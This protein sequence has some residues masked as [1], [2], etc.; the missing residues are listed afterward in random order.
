[1]EGGIETMR[2]KDNQKLT[3]CHSY[4]SFFVP[5]ALQT[6]LENELTVAFP[7]LRRLEEA[8]RH[9]ERRLL[10]IEIS[11]YM[12]ACAARGEADR[13]WEQCLR[14]YVC[15]LDSLRALEV[16]LEVKKRGGVRTSSQL[17]RQ[18]ASECMPLIFFQRIQWCREYL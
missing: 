13:G 15:E 2:A 7:C 5:L 11:E 16:F 14:K 4:Y 8:G 6:K 3:S 9:Q 1:M 18:F 10:M 12:R 17:H